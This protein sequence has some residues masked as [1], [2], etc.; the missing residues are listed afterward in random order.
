MESYKDS[1]NNIGIIVNKEGNLN[2]C[3]LYLINDDGEYTYIGDGHPKDI[4]KQVLSISSFEY[5][6]SIRKILKQKSKLKTDDIKDVLTKFSS[7]FKEWEDAQIEEEE[8]PLW[9]TPK[10]QNW[11]EKR[12]QQGKADASF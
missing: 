4:K 7:S 3:L 12:Y 9:E 6:E 10:Y 11:A 5:S 8:T 1:C 2:K